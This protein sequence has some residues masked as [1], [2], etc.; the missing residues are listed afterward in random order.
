MTISHGNIIQRLPYRSTQLKN[1]CNNRWKTGARVIATILLVAACSRT[2]AALP[3]GSWRYA[4]YLNG[5]RVG[6]ASIVNLRENGR[7]ITITEMTMKAGEVTSI[8]KQIITETEN[9]TPVKYETYNKIIKGNLT[10][11]IDTVAEFSGKKVKLTAGTSTQ[12]IEL[13]RDFKLEGN[14]FLSKL[15]EAGFKKDTKVEA[16]IYEPAI[17]PEMPIL[18]K[19]YVLGRETVKIG[20]KTYHAFHV[21]EYIE[22]FKSFDM[23]LD[24]QGALLKAELTM[25]NM[26]IQLVREMH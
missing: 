10:Q 4:L 18:M 25:L 1:K 22:K 8:S 21:I 6:S 19:A 5:N 11:D 9:F 2:P 12:E 20:E 23:Y 13:E 26:N 15:I 7:Y 16:Y 24:E 3:S 14:Y 17:D